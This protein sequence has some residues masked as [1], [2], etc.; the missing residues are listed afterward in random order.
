MDRLVEYAGPTDTGKPY[1]R[2]TLDSPHNRNALSAALVGEVRAHHDFR[3]EPLLHRV[4]QWNH[5]FFRERVG[6]D[7]AQAR[8]KRLPKLWVG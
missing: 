6:A 2:L 5:F 1:A 7:G 8:E 3:F 4:D